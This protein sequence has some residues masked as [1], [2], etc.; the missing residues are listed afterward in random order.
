MYGTTAGVSLV[1]L[2]VMYVV[3]LL[4]TYIY[5]YFRCGIAVYCTKS[6]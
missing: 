4:K 5:L 6:L 2:E 3:A 1:H